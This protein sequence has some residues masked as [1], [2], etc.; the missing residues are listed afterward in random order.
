MVLTAKAWVAFSMQAPSWELRFTAACAADPALWEQG[1]VRPDVVAV[2]EGLDPERD[3]VE[4]GRTV[5]DRLVLSGEA[6]DLHVMAGDQSTYW[7]TGVDAFPG[8]A[9]TSADLWR[10]HQDQLTRWIED[11]RVLAPLLL[12]RALQ[13]EGSHAVWLDDGGLAIRLDGDRLEVDVQTPTGCSAAE[14]NRLAIVAALS[15]ATTPGWRRIEAPG[16]S[17]VLV[18]DGFTRE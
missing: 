14:A 5:D 7:V 8:A 2:V 1:A 10:R 11:T 13:R 12:V 4:Q 15:A 3:L 17:H 6:C 9:P 16:E 18:L